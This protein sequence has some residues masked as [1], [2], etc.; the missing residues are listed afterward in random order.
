MVMIVEL[1]D[2]RLNDDRPLMKHERGN[3]ELEVRLETRMSTVSENAF[4]VRFGVTNVTV[5]TTSKPRLLPSC[6]ALHHSNSHQ[7]LMAPTLPDGA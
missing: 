5:I 7:F 1:D 6:E 3:I 2:E 4:L